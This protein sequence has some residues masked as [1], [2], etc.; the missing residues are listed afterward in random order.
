MMNKNA[1]KLSFSLKLNLNV[2]AFPR[3][4]VHVFVY[5]AKEVF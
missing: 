2:K 3:S 5:K 1:G 4:E